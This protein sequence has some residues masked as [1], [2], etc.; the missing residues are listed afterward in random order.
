MLAAGLQEHYFRDGGHR[1]SGLAVESTSIEW[2]DFD[3]L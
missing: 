2:A 3:I 1:A